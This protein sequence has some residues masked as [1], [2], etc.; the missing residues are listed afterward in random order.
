[1]Y[2]KLLQ[3]GFNSDNIEQ[4]L[5][6]FEKKGYLN[7]IEFSKDYADF[8]INTKQLGR[9]AVKYKFFPHNISKSILDP[10]LDDLYKNNPPEKIIYNILKKKYSNSNK[11]INNKTKIINFLKRKGFAWTDIS[12]VINNF[13]SEQ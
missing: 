12:S 10:I 9:K 4:V 8:L 13:I 6:E 11:M 7:D 3:K 5:N 1:M 2:N